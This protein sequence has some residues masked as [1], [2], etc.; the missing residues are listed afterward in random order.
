MIKDV[1]LIIKPQWIIPIVPERKVFQ[2]CALVINSGLI[3]ALAPCSEVDRVYR[4]KETV[5]LPGHAV[6]PGLVNAHGHSPM[7][8]LRGYAD[9]LP[10]E[11]WLEDHIWP[12]EGRWI[13]EQFVR[14]GSRLAIGEMILSGTTCFSD[15]YFFPEVTADTSVNAGMRCR[16]SFPIFEFPSIW[17]QGPDEY[18]HK[19][20]ELRDQY[21]GHPLATIDFGPHAP[22]TVSNQSLERIATLAEELD[23]RIH[24]HLHETATEVSN[25]LKEHGMRPTARMEELGIL[26]PRTEAVHMTQI[27][28]T[29]LELLHRYNTSV[30]HCPN[31][32][33]KLASGFCP[34]SK[35]RETGIQV[36]LGTDGAASNNRLDM[37]NELNSASLIAKAVSGDAAQLSAFDSLKLATLDSAKAMGLDHQIGSLEPGK[38]ADVISLKLDQLHNLPQYQVA[39][40]LC[41]AS[42]SSQVNNVWVQGRQLLANRQLLTL[43]QAEIQA[44]SLEWASKIGAGS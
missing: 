19:G 44:K 38:A 7:T 6:M 34:T 28:D 13:S 3:E 35:L 32:N 29:D 33:L 15:M 14:D 5:A 25:S 16:M 30:I 22:Y 12:A 23:A 39:S 18:I 42:A 40:Q 10:L 36:G 21:K 24:I 31:S 41:Y 9:D 27:D 26:G 20:L 37:F 11:R 8:L 1:E 4:A 17:G 2:D 43:N